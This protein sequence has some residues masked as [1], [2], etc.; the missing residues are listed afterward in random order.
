MCQDT[1]RFAVRRTTKTASQQANKQAT[2]GAMSRSARARHDDHRLGI[3]ARV[4]RA[5]ALN[6]YDDD[7][8]NARQKETEKDRQRAGADLFMSC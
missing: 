1:V 5:C 4:S 3:R 8:D 2:V 7:D 6:D